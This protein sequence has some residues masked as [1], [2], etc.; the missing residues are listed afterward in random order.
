MRVG[1]TKVGRARAPELF[2]PLLQ[3]LRQARGVTQT[4][5]YQQSGVRGIK[6]IEQRAQPPPKD[7]EVRAIARELDLKGEDR[8]ALLT[9]ATYDRAAL[10]LG[11]LTP[12]QVRELVVLAESLRAAKGARAA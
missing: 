11:E 2:G 6:Q 9:A 10:D 5:L 1:S 3:R 8:I 4:Q 12:E 7:A